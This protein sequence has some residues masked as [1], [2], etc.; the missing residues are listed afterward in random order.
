MISVIDLPPELSII[1]NYFNELKMHADGREEDHLTYGLHSED[2]YVMD[3][4]ECKGIAKFVLDCV[5]EY[6][7]QILG[8]MVEEWQFSQTWVSHKY[9]GQ[10]HEQHTHPNSVISAV[11]FY[12][13]LNG[14]TS[15]IRFHNSNFSINQNNLMV[16]VFINGNFYNQNTVSE[17]SFNPGTLIIFPSWLPHSVPENK[18][19]LV[20]KSVSMNIIPK[21]KLGDTH[22]L[23]EL[24]FNR[25]G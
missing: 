10:S 23:T 11:L 19:R 5:K 22:S 1:C 20:R 3:N 24:L 21:G 7:N 25:V 8:F 16:P 9:P 18:T 12:G 4:D 6:N 17:F 15:P 13:S 2:T 14:E